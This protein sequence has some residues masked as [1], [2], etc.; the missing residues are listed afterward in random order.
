MRNINVD[1]TRIKG[2][3]DKFFKVCAGTGRAYLL[4]RSDHQQ[5]LEIAR[6][7][8][9]FEYLRFH[10]LLDDDMGVYREDKDGN[11]VYNWQYVDSVYDYILSIGMRPFL[12]FSFMPGKLA[13]GNK[14]VYWEQSNITPPKDYAKWRKLIYEVVKHFTERY[15]CEEVKKWYFEVW[16]EPDLFCQLYTGLPS[17]SSL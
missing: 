12:E 4:L 17:L 16:N 9:G 14:T 8:C 5:H 1:L 13:S 10:G 15:G 3:H 11:P 6:R 7:E 2:K